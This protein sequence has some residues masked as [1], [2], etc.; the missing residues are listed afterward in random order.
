MV[1]L[2]RRYAA[3]A[4]AGVW[5][6]VLGATVPRAGGSILPAP[7]VTDSAVP[8]NGSFTAQNTLDNTEAEFASAG[9]GLDTYVTYSFGAPQSFDKIVVINRNSAGQSDYIGDFTL[10]LDGGSTTSVTR[11]PLRGTSAIHALGALRTT[12]TVRLDVDS[13]G[14]GDV[15]NN[16]GAME[17]IFVRT[18]AGH[19]PV[20]ATIV[21]AAPDFSPFYQ[22]ANAVDGLVGRSTGAGERGPEYASAGQGNNTFVDFDLGAVIPVGGFDFFDRPA[23]EDRVTGFDMIFSQNATFGD[24]DDVVKSYLSTGMALGDVFPGVSARYVRFDVTSSAAANTGISEMVFYQ[25]PEPS[26]LGVCA[27]GLVALLRRRGR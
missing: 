5:A 3:V 17:V 15:F 12:T 7:V 19:T 20:P 24:G 4:S 25:V 26:S 8:F 1:R 11:T 22:V 14:V 27:V 16:T 6:L 9:Q 23:D 2:T 18:P 10:T 13:I 21:Q